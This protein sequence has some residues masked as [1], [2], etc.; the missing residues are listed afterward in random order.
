M[1]NSDD[2]EFALNFE[3]TIRLIAEKD[4]DRDEFYFTVARMDQ[5]LFM[6]A[7]IQST[8]MNYWP[9]E[10]KRLVKGGQYVQAIKLC[11][12]QTGYGLKEAKRIIDAW[13]FDG[14]WNTATGALDDW[15][16]PDE[17]NF[18]NERKALYAQDNY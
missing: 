4:I 2:Q 8:I 7:A 6:K 5:T 13:R 12:Q 15:E 18:A 1:N 17:D 3:R 9:I 11:R 10:A 16:K 14:I